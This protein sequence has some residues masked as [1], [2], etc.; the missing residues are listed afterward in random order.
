M[1]IKVKPVA[2]MPDKREGGER[3]GERE[4]ERERVRQTDRQTDK[5]RDPTDPH[6]LPFPCS[7][8]S[9]LFPSSLNES[10]DAA[11]A[12]LDTTN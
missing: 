8:T 5:E 10:V 12:D 1:K 7:L 4:R 6:K 2:R 3:E 11:L 9:A